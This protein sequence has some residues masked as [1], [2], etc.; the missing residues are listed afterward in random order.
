MEEQN[1]RNQAAQ[2]HQTQR[3]TEGDYTVHQDNGPMTGTDPVYMQL[4]GRHALSTHAGNPTFNVNVN[5]F[6]GKQYNGQGVATAEQQAPHEVPEGDQYG[7]GNYIYEAGG[8]FTVDA[9]Q[10]EQQQQYRQR[11]QPQGRVIRPPPGLTHPSLSLQ[12]NPPP[13]ST[14]DRTPHPPRRY[15]WTGQPTE[16]PRRPTYESPY[17]PSPD[18][19]QTAPG[20]T[21]LPMSQFPN[22][23]GKMQSLF[24]MFHNGSSA[25]T[26]P[27]PQ[28]QMPVGYSPDAETPPYKSRGR[29]R[30][31]KRTRSSSPTPENQR[32]P[33]KRLNTSSEPGSSQK[34]QPDA[35]FPGVHGQL[36]NESNRDD[37]LASHTDFVPL[38]EYHNWWCTAHAINARESTI[39]GYQDRFPIRSMPY[40][41]IEACH[42]PWLESDTV[43]LLPRDLWRCTDMF[44]KT[45]VRAMSDFVLVIGFLIVF[46]RRSAQMRLTKRGEQLWSELQRFTS[47]VRHRMLLDSYREPLSWMGPIPKEVLFS[48]DDFRDYAYCLMYGLAMPH[49]DVLK[50]SPWMDMVRQLHTVFGEDFFSKDIGTRWRMYTE[51]TNAQALRKQAAEAEASLPLTPGTASR[52]VSEARTDDPQL[53]SSP[54]LLGPNRG[55]LNTTGVATSPSPVPQESVG[56]MIPSPSEANPDPTGT[57]GLPARHEA[58][59]SEEGDGLSPDE[60]LELFSEPENES[61]NDDDQAPNQANPPEV[62]HLNQR[63]LQP[64][65]ADSEVAVQEEIHPQIEIQIP[66]QEIG[67]R[68]SPKPSIR[69]SHGVIQENNTLHHGIAQTETGHIGKNTPSRKRKRPNSTGP[70]RKHDN[71]LGVTTSRADCYIVEHNDAYQDGLN[72]SHKSLK[73]RQPQPEPQPEN[74]HSDISDQSEAS[75]PPP[76]PATNKPWGSNDVIVRTQA[77]VSRNE[78]I[79]RPRDEYFALYTALGDVGRPLPAW[80]RIGGAI[81]HM[82]DADK[83]DLR[84]RVKLEEN[85]GPMDGSVAPEPPAQKKPRASKKY[86]Q[87]TKPEDLNGPKYNLEHPDNVAALS[88]ESRDHVVD[89]HRR[90]SCGH[91]GGSCQTDCTHPC[92]KGQLRWSKIQKA[93]VSRR[94]SIIRRR[95]RLLTDYPELASSQDDAPPNG[96]EV[97]E[98]DPAGDGEAI[99]DDELA[100]AL[101]EGLMDDED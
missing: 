20:H 30:E 72:Q 21:F 56:S 6:A 83:R 35:G 18:A 55:L 12:G 80:A 24:P 75:I 2:T 26:S 38:T 64:R 99:G 67:I 77:H 3:V 16:P 70:K 44:G 48:K 1:D 58:E 94:K 51:W 17:G 8:T 50:M 32:R 90:C 52:S 85:S 95:K 101:L 100:Q 79:P 60:E 53:Q 73:L 15:I 9:E 7:S 36:N 33:A 76:R 91:G 43:P 46:E 69:A 81:S 31:S 98:G 45:H 88:V 96:P 92:C 29:K 71:S 11:Y 34:G 28:A 74:G 89:E 66:I 41:N 19:T 10:L 40:P 22:N 82:R 14:L 13:Y 5:L 27:L 59:G 4:N 84:R 25:G 68:E 61:P 78:P 39:F 62:E 86:R 54:N 63:N 97:P 49:M 93:L 57:D 23:N 87:P 65:R 47:L 37:V 42:A